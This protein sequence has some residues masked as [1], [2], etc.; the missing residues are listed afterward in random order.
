ML[1]FLVFPFLRTDRRIKRLGVIVVVVDELL[2]RRLYG[3]LL[4]VFAV[5]VAEAVIIYNVVGFTRRREG[6]VDDGGIDDPIRKRGSGS[7][8]GVD[9]IDG[10]L[11]SWH[12]KRRGCMDRRGRDGREIGCGLQSSFGLKLWLWHEAGFAG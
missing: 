5:S 6:R 11:E 3:H 1:G 10:V 8:H 7:D 9:G 12:H 4:R 2:L